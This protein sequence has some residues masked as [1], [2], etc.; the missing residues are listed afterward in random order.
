M[1][2]KHFP[3]DRFDGSDPQMLERLAQDKRLNNAEFF[4]INR[5]VIAFALAGSMVG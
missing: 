3:V 2:G 1:G 5:F 4:L